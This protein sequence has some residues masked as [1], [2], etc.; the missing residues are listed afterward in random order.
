MRQSSLILKSLSDTKAAARVL[1]DHCLIQDILIFSGGLGV[2]KSEF[3][4]HLAQN[5]GTTLD[6][7]SPTYDLMRMYPIS[8]GQLLHCDVYR[9]RSEK[10]FLHLD[11]ESYIDES[12]VAIEWGESLVH[13]FDSYLM[14][15]L[16]FQPTNPNSRQ[17]SLEFVGESWLQ[18][19]F[20]LEDALSQSV[21]K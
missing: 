10:E 3:I 8:Q 21:G 5:L 19:K 15:S 14:L 9:L 16:S 4:R 18:R 2:G 12:I 7:R 11:V 1:S 13:L 17:L 6:V 20:K